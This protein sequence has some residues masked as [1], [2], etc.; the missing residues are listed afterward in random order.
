MYEQQLEDPHLRQNEHW[1][2]NIQM[3]EIVEKSK[4]RKATGNGEILK[5][6][7]EK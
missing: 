5:W 7:P 3:S 4:S 1:N 2:K 6:S